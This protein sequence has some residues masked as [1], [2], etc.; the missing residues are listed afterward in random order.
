MVGLM[1][2][3]TNER[4]TRKAPPLR[5]DRG[6][7]YTS[8]IEHKPVLD[9]PRAFQLTARDERGAGVVIPLKHSE[10]ETLR[11]M[12]Q[13]HLD[14]HTVLMVTAE[15]L[16][17]GDTVWDWSGVSVPAT[18]ERTQEPHGSNCTVQ[19][20]GLDGSLHWV[21]GSRR[22]TVIVRLPRPGG[23]S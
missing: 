11:D 13:A 12:C 9:S 5:P 8:L 6:A 22:A 18:V 16:R 15:E 17:P 20:Q 7:A 23:D 2:L 19:V 14:A 1:H 3:Y 4:G 21:T 10:V